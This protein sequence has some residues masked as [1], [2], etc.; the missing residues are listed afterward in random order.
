MRRKNCLTQAYR[1]SIGNWD[2]GISG[3][4]ATLWA[5]NDTPREN[6]THEID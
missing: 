4:F 2:A 1:W 3:T 5:L 6:I